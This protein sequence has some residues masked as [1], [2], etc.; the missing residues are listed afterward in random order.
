MT[1]IQMPPATVACPI[2]ERPTQVTLLD[3]SRPPWRL[4]Q[5]QQSGFVFLENPPDYAR[6][7]DEFAWEKSWQ[8]EQQR[9]A[10]EQP[11][12]TRVSTFLKR[13]KRIVFPRRNKFLALAHA[14]I[15][16]QDRLSLLDVGCGSGH[17]IGALCEHYQRLGSE[18]VPF[19]VEVSEQLAA[20]AQ[21]QFARAGGDVALLPATEGVAQFSPQQFD[22]VL[23]CSFLEHEAQPLTLL[24]LTHRA[25]KPSGM[26]IIKVPNYASWNRR[27][28]RRKW[29][30]FRY[31]DH[32]NYFTPATLRAVAHEAGFRIARQFPLDALPW[33]DSMYMVL[34]KPATFAPAS[35]ALPSTM[36]PAERTTRAAA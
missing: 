25:L 7:A 13:L 3:D 16:P 9:K 36:A 12:A 2:T 4:V 27:V 32:V 6:L 5:C 31:P 23:M 21:R 10:A 11:I 24:R 26:V 15:E 29:C 8:D 17:L 35:T 1:Q 34:K 19:G 33:S 18:V 20:V 28:R 14:V 22:A 30:A